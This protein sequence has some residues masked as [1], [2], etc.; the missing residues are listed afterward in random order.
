M[1][2]MYVYVQ[3]VFRVVG[4]IDTVAECYSAEIAIHS[5]W[6]EPLHDGRVC[7]L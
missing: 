4:E 3:V 7:P 6:R 1:F 5:R 2:Q